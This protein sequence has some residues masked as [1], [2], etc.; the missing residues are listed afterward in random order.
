MYTRKIRFNAADG[1]LG[2]INEVND[3]AFDVDL[4]IDRYIVDA[5]SLVGVLTLNFRRDIEFIAHTT[6]KDEIN[7]VNSIL[8]KYTNQI[9]A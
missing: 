1:V 5:K 8:E 3:L 6:N 9:A 7:K 4:K 2:F